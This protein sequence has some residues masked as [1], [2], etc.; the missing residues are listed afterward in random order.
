LD[1]LNKLDSEF[2]SVSEHQDSTD[3][4]DDDNNNDAEDDDDDE[5]AATKSEQMARSKSNASPSHQAQQSIDSNTN[6]LA[7]SLMRPTMTTTTTAI[8]S[9]SL[10]RNKSFE[11]GSIS[12]CPVCDNDSE[13]ATICV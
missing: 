12:N 13:C 11:T 8:D 3:D 4:D 9:N 1:S 6:S 2:D 10:K 5:D 7:T